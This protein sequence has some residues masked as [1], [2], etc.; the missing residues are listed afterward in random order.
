MNPTELSE[1]TLVA[2][3]GLAQGVEEEVAG[4]NCS[5]AAVGQD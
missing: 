4:S 1:G 5:I 2:E 3:V